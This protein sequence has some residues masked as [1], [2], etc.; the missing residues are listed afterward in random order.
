M[1]DIVVSV[2]MGPGQLDFIRRLKER[3]FIVAAFGKGKNSEEAMKIAD[4]TAEIDTRDYAAAEAWI[5]AL[6][7]NV[8]AIGSYS[9]GAAVRTVVELSNYYNTTTRVPEKLIYANSKIEQQKFLEGFGLSSIKTF[10]LGTMKD[11]KHLLREDEKYVVKP[12]SGRGSEGIKIVTFDELWRIYS[13]EAAIGYNTVVQTF[14]E[15]TEYR[16]VLI[17]KDG[18]IRLMAPI[19]RTSY[20]DTVFLGVLE[21]SAND[22][23]QMTAF[24]NRFVDASGIKNAIIKTDILVGADTIDVIEMDIGAGGG[25]YYKKYV[26]KVYGIDLMDEYIN[27]VTGNNISEFKVCNSKLKMEYVFNHCDCPI[28]YDLDR[29]YDELNRKYEQVEIVTNIL[30]PESKG[31][32]KSN[33]DFIFTVIRN[34]SRENGYNI[35][36]VDE[37]VNDNLFFKA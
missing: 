36:E 1:K 25:S 20:R 3:G 8:I 14:K 33:A 35:F 17:V 32:F 31:G 15:G 12:E 2:G 22:L 21:Y 27:L 37:F 30:H 4:Y 7:E 28:Y 11:V 26:G 34:E 13:N 24:F 18:I 5:D 6:H 19:K 10:Y 23:T 16:C 29:C 9:G